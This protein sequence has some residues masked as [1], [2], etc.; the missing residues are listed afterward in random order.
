MYDDSYQNAEGLYEDVMEGKWTWDRLR[1][2]SATVWNDL[3]SDGVPSWDD[4]LGFGINDYN[5]IDAL[6]RIVH[7]SSPP[8]TKTTSPSSHSTPNAPPT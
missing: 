5:N 7:K 1:E 4:R 8:A 6:Y 2:I 3:D